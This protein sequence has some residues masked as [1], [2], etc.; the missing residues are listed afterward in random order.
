IENRGAIL[1]A[2][3]FGFVWELGLF[4]RIASE[5]AGEQFSSRGAIRDF[6]RG[7]TSD[8]GVSAERAAMTAAA[9][10]VLLLLVRLVSMVWAAVRLHGFTLRLVDGDARTEYGLLTR[11]TMT[12]P[13][14]RI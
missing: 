2:A 8:A 4:D 6:V 1:I 5:L 12:V 11:M 3:A 7:I 9:F 14:W 10:L 13:L